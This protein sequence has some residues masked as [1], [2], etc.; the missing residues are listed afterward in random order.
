MLGAE[1]FLEQVLEEPATGVAALFVEQIRNPQKLLRLAARARELSKRIVLM[2]P[3]RT[4]RAQ[5]AAQSHTG[6]FAGDLA[7]ARTI[8]AHAG[9]AVVDGLDAL[10]DVTLLLAT[11]PVPPAGRTAFM[12][13]SG[14]VRGLAFDF[15]QEAGLELAEWSPATAAGLRQ[16]FPPF[17]R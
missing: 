2:Q 6:A 5:A 16:I 17:A 10:V 13:N 4:E 3:G 9:V 12:T 1:D 7:V 8:L 15:A 14:A 11:R